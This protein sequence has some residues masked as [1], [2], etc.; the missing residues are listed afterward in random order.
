VL[1][2]LVEEILSSGYLPLEVGSN[3][4]FLLQEQAGDLHTMMCSGILD[5]C[6]E[7]LP[8]GLSLRFQRHGG[9]EA[10]A[11]IRGCSG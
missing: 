3:I 10:M 5:K 9:E 8:K 11:P 2:A 4:L 6:V 1:E 7:P